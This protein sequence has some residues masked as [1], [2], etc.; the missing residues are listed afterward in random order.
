[1][2]SMDV[3]THPGVRRRLNAA[4]TLSRLDESR[5]KDDVLP[6]DPIVLCPEDDATAARCLLQTLME[7]ES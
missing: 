2:N 6:F 1:M 5:I 3:L 4:G 7:I